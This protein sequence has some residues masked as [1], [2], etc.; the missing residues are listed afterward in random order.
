[1][2]SDIETF[3][4]DILGGLC[5]IKLM[6]GKRVATVSSI[7]QSSSLR[8]ERTYHSTC[9]TLF[10]LLPEEMWHIPDTRLNHCVVECRYDKEGFLHL[11]HECNVILWKLLQYQSHFLG[12]SQ[13]NTFLI[14]FPSNNEIHPLLKVPEK[15]TQ[16]FNLYKTH[17]FAF[18]FWPE[19]LNHKS[20][21]SNFFL[22]CHL[23]ATL[24]C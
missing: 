21:R 9:S 8:W 3:T 17:C 6:I 11:H 19:K 2:Q 12:R 10:L 24:K 16:H 1:M 23:T 13:W 14:S 22:P 20:H 18:T 4:G 5:V 15:W 7:Q